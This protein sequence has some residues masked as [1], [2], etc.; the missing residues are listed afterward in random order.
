MTQNERL[1]RYLRTHKSITPMEAWSSLGIY[2]LGARIH[3]LKK[4]GHIIDSK[5][6]TVQNMF[7]EDCQ[8]A[9]Y[10]LHEIEK[11]PTTMEN[12]EFVW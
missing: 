6:A 9:M 3:D 2:R 12:E 5:T 7:G 1:L 10:S 4:A 8:V 11:I